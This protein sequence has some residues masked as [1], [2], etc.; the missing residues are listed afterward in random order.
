MRER[1][2][3]KGREGWK[4]GQERRA[5]WKREGRREGGTWVGVVVT[6]FF[7][8]EEVDKELLLAVITEVEGQQASFLH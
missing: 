6:C 1:K 2:R 4:G 3:G 7:E 8:A 5:L